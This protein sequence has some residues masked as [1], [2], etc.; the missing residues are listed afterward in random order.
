MK[1]RQWIAAS[2]VTAAAIIFIGFFL[3]KGNDGRGSG[4]EQ[5]MSQTPQGHVHGAPPEPSTRQPDQGQ[6]QMPDMETGSQPVQEPPPGTDEEE[7][8]TIEI[9]QDMQRLIGVKTVAAAVAPMTKTVRL[10]GSIEYNEQ[11]LFTVNTKVEGWIEKLH[12][13]YTGRYLKKGEPVLEIYSP[14]LQAAQQELINISAWN[15]P[16]EAS[17]TEKLVSDDVEHLK[18]AARQRLRLWD[19]SDQQIRKIENTGKPLRTLTITSPVSGY[20]VQ[21]RATRGMRVMAGEPLLDIAD[22]SDVWVVAEVNEADAG[23]IRQ[24]QQVNISVTALP[25]KVFPSRIDYV[26]PS[27]NPETRTLRVRCTLRNPGNIMKPAMFASVDLKV[28]MGR[29]LAVPETAVMDTGERQVVYVDR[30]EGLFEPRQVSTGIRT[31]GMSEVLSG[32]KAGERIAASAL[33]LI[34]SEAQLEGV[35]PAAPPAHQH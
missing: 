35:T 10:T 17:S 14:D 21:R 27:M 24:G 7:V 31:G 30:G 29:R 28:D 22:L 5:G 32:L 33:F 3:M 20:V 25:G 26:Y 2:I 8:P 19:I 13:D 18:E 15:Q 4:E 9:P 11:K 12:V 34:D 16:G 1:K 23:L 6:G